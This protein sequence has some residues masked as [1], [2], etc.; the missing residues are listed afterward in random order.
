[1]SSNVSEEVKE[2]IISEQLELA[3][4]DAAHMGVSKETMTGWFNKIVT[5]YN[6]K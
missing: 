5:K 1:M 2:K 6:L 4:I 3:T